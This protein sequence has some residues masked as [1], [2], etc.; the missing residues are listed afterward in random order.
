[1][2]P[3]LLFIE[4]NATDGD[5][6]VQA[7]FDGQLW[8]HVRIVG[9]TGG[10]IVETTDPSGVSG[11]DLT[12]FVPEDREPTLTQLLQM[13]PPGD[14]SFRG[15]GVDGGRLEGTGRLS[16]DVP[17]PAVVVAIDPTVPVIFWTWVPGPRSPIR[18]LAGF[19]VTLEN[20]R[21]IAVSFDLHPSTMSLAVPRELLEPGTTYRVDVL[22]IAANGN[23]TVT[24]TAFVTP[25]RSGQGQ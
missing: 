22:A 14:Y 12:E 1:M 20:A 7:F 19:R 10:T 24:E 18:E 11:V 4:Y 13:F 6:A 15:T 9:P 8:T 17:D 25:R 2:V 16:Y 3:V 23:R 5:A 21:E